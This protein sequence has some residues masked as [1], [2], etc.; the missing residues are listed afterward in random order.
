[1]DGWM[2]RGIGEGTDSRINGWMDG[3]KKKF[4]DGWM[5]TSINE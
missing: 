4:V 3:C 1:M 2:A 5:D